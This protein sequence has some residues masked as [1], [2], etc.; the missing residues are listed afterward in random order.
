MNFWKV[1]Y[2]GTHVGQDS[3]IENFDN[4]IEYKDSRR[5]VTLPWKD[6]YKNIPGNFVPER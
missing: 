4:A 2:T 3:F 1:E 5:T 6:E